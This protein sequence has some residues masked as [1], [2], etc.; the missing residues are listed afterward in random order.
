[1]SWPKKDDK[2]AEMYA[3]YQ[4]GMSLAAVAERFG[5]TRQAV[6]GLFKWRGWPLRAKV[7]LPHIEFNGAKYTMRNT[8]Y[9]AKTDGKRTLLHRDMWEFYNGPI[10]HGFDVHHIDEDRLHNEIGNFECL[11]KSDHTRLHQ[12]KIVARRSGLFGGT[13]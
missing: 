8:G 13:A 7:P 9:Y 4:C 10:P 12:K 1:M 11:P 5:N 2:A 6:Y 3:L